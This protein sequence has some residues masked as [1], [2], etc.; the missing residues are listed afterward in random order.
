MADFNSSLFNSTRPVSTASTDACYNL[1]SKNL[2]L[3]M[4]IL[5]VC[6]MVILVGLTGNALI[7][8]IIVKNKPM[9]AS[10]NFFLINMAV[11]DI[12]VV[13]FMVPKKASE[14]LTDHLGWLVPG[15]TGRVLCKLVPFLHDV[16]S[17]G[18]TYS[19]LLITLDRFIAVVLPHKRWLSS[20][21]IVLVIISCAWVASF[22]VNAVILKTVR[23]VRFNSKIYCMSIWDSSREEFLAYVFT[24]ITIHFIFPIIFIP[25]AYTAIFRKLKLQF[26]AS[27][28]SISNQNQIHDLLRQR[29]IVNMAFAIVCGFAICWTPLALQGILRFTVFLD[30]AVLPCPFRRFQ[31]A[32]HYFLL[33]IAVTNPVICFTFGTVFKENLKRLYRRL[34]GCG[35]RRASVANTDIELNI[36]RVEEPE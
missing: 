32:S 29:K 5:I 22:S 7:V 31:D 18:S 4:F 9:R 23:L 16:F 27:R 28:N 24:M 30:Q 25:T 14:V 11:C 17:E 15:F 8:Y 34:C 19:L 36:D 6:I 3:R 21:F 13:C 2:E 1:L 20:K 10:T 33:F 12:G 35:R 26:A